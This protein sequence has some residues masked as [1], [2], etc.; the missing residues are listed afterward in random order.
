MSQTPLLVSSRLP[1]VYGEFV[2]DAFDSG[3]PE[4]PHLVL[5]NRGSES[6][7]VNVRIHSECLT[8]DVFGSTR[9]DCGEQLATSLRYIEDHGGVLVYLRQEGRGIGLVNKM[10]AYNL[11]DQGMDTIVANH[12]LGF[13][14]DLRNYSEA[15]T[16]LKQLGISRINL[17]TNNPDKLDAFH[18]SGITIENRIPI[19]IDPRPENRTYL[20]TKKNALG[21]F[22]G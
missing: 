20:D 22:L 9:C 12:H 8:G 17:I 1:T 2:M 7:I 11:Q 15:I 16:I 10:K 13:H 18:E 21:H 6:P 3:R 14:A 19:L 4:M 5:R